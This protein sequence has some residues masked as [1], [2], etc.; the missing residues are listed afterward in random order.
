MP[1]IM[2]DLETLG[3]RA[4]CVILSIG[5]VM[6]C[7]T[8]G[9]V[10]DSFYEVINIASCEKKGLHSDQSTLDWWQNQSAEARKVLEEAKTSPQGLGG[11]LMKF[12]GYLQKYGKKDLCIWGNG[13]EFDNVI[14]TEAYRVCGLPLPWLFYKNRCFRT[15]KGLSTIPYD[16]PKFGVAHNAL[17]DA[18]G[19]AEAAIRMMR[20]LGV[21]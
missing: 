19:Q 6:F 7:P 1:H 3:N 8:T 18:K 20:Q 14:L 13:S 4:G 9:D 10:R 21:S 12:Q 2:L 15:L 11:A 17:D 16:K 5:A